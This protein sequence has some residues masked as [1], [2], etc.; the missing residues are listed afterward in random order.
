M[1]TNIPPI[2]PKSGTSPELKPLEP[3]KEG[4]DAAGRTVS[5]EPAEEVLSESMIAQILAYIEQTINNIKDM[6][7]SPN[8]IN[9]ASEKIQSVTDKVSKLNLEKI[10]T[11]DYKK[12]MDGV[13]S[14]KEINQIFHKTSSYNQEHVEDQDRIDMSIDTLLAKLDPKKQLRELEK[15]RS[16]INLLTTEDLVNVI[17]AYAKSA[18]EEE[19]DNE[20]PSVQ[21]K[22]DRAFMLMELDVLQEALDR[23]HL[24]DKESS[25]KTEEGNKMVALDNE[26]Y[27]I[28]SDLIRGA[29]E[30]IDPASSKKA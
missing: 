17:K 25:K 3:P 19:F 13:V 10:S 12:I 11:N 18:S 23:S 6:L 22:R 15:F 20:E 30:H 7:I 21:E 27:E 28:N 24:G 14:S 16:E 8:K 2:S 5:Q 29:R 4:M 26:L 9:V 1:T